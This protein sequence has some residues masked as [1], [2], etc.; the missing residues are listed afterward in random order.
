MLR[1]TGGSTGLGLTGVATGAAVAG[2]L[3]ERPWTA[4]GAMAID[5]LVAW[6]FVAQ[7]AGV[8]ATAGL[9]DIEA[10]AAGYD[11]ARVSTDGCAKIESIGQLNCRIDVSRGGPSG[12]AHPVA[13]AVVAAVEGS[14]HREMLLPWA[15]AGARP[16]GWAKPERWC[17]PLHGWVEGERYVAAAP[18]YDAIGGKAGGSRRATPVLFRDPGAVAEEVERARAVYRNWWDAMDGVGFVLGCSNLGFAVL[19]PAAAMQPWA[20]EVDA[21]EAGA[22]PEARVWMFAARWCA[23]SVAM[24]WHLDELAGGEA[25][26]RI[27]VDARPDL[28]L[29]MGVRALPCMVVVQGREA[30]AMV[31]GAMS[32]PPLRKWL[33]QALAMSC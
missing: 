28:A 13:D 24:G 6:A 10:A 7:R 18:I 31:P 4:T 5:D 3:A 33:Q 9:Y 30:A 32:K 23:L 15:R 17:E 22:W 27:D 16:G 8:M 2:R 29:A 11:R 12:G 20:R 19:P 25:V 14:P 21:V 1:R 26:A